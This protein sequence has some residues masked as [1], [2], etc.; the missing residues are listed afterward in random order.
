MAATVSAHVKSHFN[1]NIDSEFESSDSSSF[2][3]SIGSLVNVESRT[4][5]GINK[6]GGVGRITA[7]H[8]EDDEKD[9]RFGA[10]PK[11][12]T[13]VDVKYVVG[14]GKET[15][16]DVFF[17]KEHSFENN[18]GRRRSFQAE[19]ENQSKCINVAESNIR[20]LED[21]KTTGT[22]PNKSG[23]KNQFSPLKK[24]RTYS[25]RKAKRSS[26]ART[27]TPGSS[28]KKKKKLSIVELDAIKN[29][30]EKDD[31]VKQ[32]KALRLANSSGNIISQEKIFKREIK[33]LESENKKISNSL[34]SKL[35]ST[36]PVVNKNATLNFQ[37]REKEVLKG[38]YKKI[39]SNAV[40]FVDGMV[41][42]SSVNDLVAED[43]ISSSSDSSLSDSTELD[44][45][46]NKDR[47]KVF[48]A[49]LNEVML[50]LMEDE[51]KIDD[52]LHQINAKSKD[53]SFTGLESKALFS[54]LEDLNRVM[55]VW[56]TRTLYRI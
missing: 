17:V 33:C 35:I 11:L 56:E 25:G 32:T 30:H 34:D 52:L 26:V 18:R 47:Q 19:Q 24:L 42:L 21:V 2:L 29:I 9:V 4:W 40:K 20:I 51:I 5:A 12:V 49:L 15:Y 39:S 45:V 38:V 16:V 41:G 44:M 46:V 3:P 6:P 10:K 43:K 36:L 14:T 27:V 7:V 55:I 22:F 1:E 54:N 31:T 48:N 28:A 23:T 13:S 53:I 50:H 8:Y 37:D